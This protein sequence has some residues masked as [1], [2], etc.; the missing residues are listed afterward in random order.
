MIIKDL[1]SDLAG[2]KLSES[3]AKFIEGA[4]KY[5]KRNKVLSEKQLNILLEMRKYAV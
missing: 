5:F 1:F 4:K 3:Q 2:K